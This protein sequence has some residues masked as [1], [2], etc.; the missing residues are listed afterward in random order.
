MRQWKIMCMTLLTALLL[1]G[2]AMRTVDQMYSLP[3]RS[4][5]YSNL[6]AAIDS[7][8]TGLE[9]AAPQSGEN[10]Q[11]VQ[12]AD[13]DG[14]GTDE[15]LLFARD[16]VDLVPKILVFR[17]NGEEY[18]LIAVMENPGFS[19]EQVE[20]VNVD[21]RPGME[22]VVGC[23]VGDQV[24]RAISVYT[25]A[26]DKPVQLMSANYSKFMTCDLNSDGSHEIFLLL[27]GETEADSGI[28]VLY[29]FR[30]GQMERS[31]E[32]NLSRMVT[33]VKRMIFGRLQS[34]EPAVFVASAVNESAVITDIFAVKQGR[35]SN[36]SLSGDAEI[37]VQTLRNYYIYADDLDNDGIL[38]LPS[39]ITMPQL[40]FQSMVERQYLIRWYSM[41]L[42]GGETDKQYTYHNFT[43][44]WYLEL[45]PE[46]SSRISV[47]QSG[48]GY[49]F[50]L[51]DEDYQ[52]AQDLL[53]IYALAGPD[54]ED[55]AQ[56][57]GYFVLY[58][59]DGILYAGKLE[60]AALAH[61]ITPDEM[62]KRF[63]LIHHDW[64][65]GET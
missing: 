61:A 41:D 54:R 31:R 24:L 48:N 17:Q 62:T 4:E 60:S 6:Q 65:T 32:V 59:G 9:Y 10:Q 43:G 15:Y 5:A 56:E 16:T 53:S 42:H 27:P 40:P 13:L 14:D 52:E 28:A 63:H 57:E 30:A 44:G 25:F 11:T 39:L 33:D 49:R 34:G 12:Q 20:Y 23:Q 37:S 18:D 46:L 2:C 64:K 45:D 55:R 35:F 51:W 47:R 1:S 26:M 3:K 22:I 58:R 21:D 50:Y 8:M 38:E 29:S 36:I 19:F 7:A